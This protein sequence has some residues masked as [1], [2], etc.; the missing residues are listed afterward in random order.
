MLGH[1]IERHAGSD[2]AANQQN[3]APARVEFA[4]EDH[5][6]LPAVAVTRDFHKAATEFYVERANQIG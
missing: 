6:R 4:G 5:F 3:V 1:I 2:D